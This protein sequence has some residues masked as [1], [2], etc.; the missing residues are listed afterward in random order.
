MFP[1]TTTKTAKKSEK[2]VNE[3]EVS[4]LLNKE[5]KVIVIKLLIKLCRQ[6]D[7]C[8]ENFNKEV[9]SILKVPIRT[10]KYNN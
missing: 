9:K 8:S 7:K 3:T 10:K 5:F 6:V 4:C 2:E 1:T